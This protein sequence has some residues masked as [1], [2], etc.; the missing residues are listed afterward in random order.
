[1]SARAGAKRVVPSFLWFKLT[2]VRSC[3]VGCIRR[4]ESEGHEDTTRECERAEEREQRQ[5]LMLD[6]SV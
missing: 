6:A 4:R 5:E 2:V 3:Q 1:M